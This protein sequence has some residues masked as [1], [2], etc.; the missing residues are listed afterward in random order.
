[1]QHSNEAADPKT[2]FN[3]T[4]NCRLFFFEKFDFMV[5][6]QNPQKWRL[7][8]KTV[9]KHSFGLSYADDAY[10]EKQFFFSF[11]D[12]ISIIYHFMEKAIWCIYNAVFVWRKNEKKF[13]AHHKTQTAIKFTCLLKCVNSYRKEN[14]QSEG[15]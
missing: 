1:M 7:C 3:F 8:D 11:L 15:F 14:K 9:I 2:Y 10:L 5:N 12:G 13:I 4:S 6:L